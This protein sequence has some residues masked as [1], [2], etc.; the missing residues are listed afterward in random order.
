MP[1]PPGLPAAPGLPQRPMFGAPPVNAA[2]MQQ[3]HQ[4]QFAAQNGSQNAH[5]QDPR[6]RAQDA[7]ASTYGQSQPFNDSRAQDQPTATAADVDE[8]VANAARESGVSLEENKPA[9]EPV[10]E[11]KSK[12]DKD[13]ATRLVYSD[14]ELSPE[15]KMAKLSRYAFDPTN[16]KPETVLSSAVEPAVTGPV[17]GQD[18]VLD[19][20]G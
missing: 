8:L 7:A 20:A 12:K 10:E 17:E 3:M 6:L 5:S 2:Q 16:E 14:N 13:K 9:P 15:E 18:D 1:R 4:G 11:K 19:A